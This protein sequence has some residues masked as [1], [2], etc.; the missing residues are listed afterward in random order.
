VTGVECSVA[1]FLLGHGRPSDFIVTCARAETTG[2]IKSVLRLDNINEKFIGRAGG[3]A[4]RRFPLK[5]S[6]LWRSHVRAMRVQRET[7][8]SVCEAEVS[9]GA[10]PLPSVA[11][12]Q[13]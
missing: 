4:G 9:T 8:T 3:F 5:I 12:S 2:G 10:L 11:A 13:E 7:A 1:G 6:R